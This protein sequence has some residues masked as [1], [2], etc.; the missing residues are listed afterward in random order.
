MFVYSSY[1]HYSIYFSILQ[2]LEER[3]SAFN[4]LS[5]NDVDREKWKQILVTEVISSDESES[6][7]RKG[8]FFA[9]NLQWRSDTVTRFFSKLDDAQKSRKS[10]Q[11]A[12]QTK[13]LLHQGAV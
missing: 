6:E 1:I 13:L 2:R 4:R 11:A 5:Y 9:K 12:R 3:L 7:D 10:E 8:V